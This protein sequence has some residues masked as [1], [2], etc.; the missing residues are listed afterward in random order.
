MSTD[1][2]PWNPKCTPENVVHLPVGAVSRSQR[3]YMLALHYLKKKRLAREKEGTL[4]G[5]TFYE[6]EIS[7]LLRSL[8]RRLEKVFME[9]YPP[10]VRREVFHLVWCASHYAKIR[11]AY[12]EQVYKKLLM[13]VLAVD[14]IMGLRPS[15]LF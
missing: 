1:A 13:H 12:P 9:E 8:Q 4:R 10:R 7:V 11:R 14:R 2:L 6:E 5:A 3:L 15:Y